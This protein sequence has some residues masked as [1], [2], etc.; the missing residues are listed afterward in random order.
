ML[1]YMRQEVQMYILLSVISLNCHLYK[2]GDIVISSI[3]MSVDS[4]LTCVSTGGPATTVTWTRGNDEDSLMPVSD[5][6]TV[7]VLENAVTAHYIHTFNVTGTELSTVYECHVSNNKP[8][9]AK[10]IAK[11]GILRFKHLCNYSLS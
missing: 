1:E 10:G 2:P 6:T 7:S 4:I 8:S 5:K 9:S 3:S 11:H